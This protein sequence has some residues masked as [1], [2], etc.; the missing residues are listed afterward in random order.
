MSYSIDF[1]LA[2]SDQIEQALC[3]RL[4]RIRLSLNVTQA[5]LAEEAGISRKTVGRLERGEGTSLDTFIRVLRVLGIERNIEAVLPD[6]SVRPVE[7]IGS[8]QRERQRA[9]PKPATPATS[10]TWGDEQ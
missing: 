10:W 3:A 2:T 1:E 6:P 7:R 9:R 5:Q 4:E 8:T